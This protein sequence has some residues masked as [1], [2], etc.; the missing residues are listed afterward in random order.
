[1]KDPF[2]SPPASFVSFLQPVASSLSLPV[3][4]LHIHEVLLG[5]AAYHVLDVYISP[6]LSRAL[7]PQTYNSLNLRTRI[8]WNMRVAAWAQAVFISALALGVKYADQE[9]ADMSWNGRLW[10]YSGGIGMVQG[11]ALGYFLWDLSV[12]IIHYSLLG[13]ETLAH[14][15]SALVMILLAFV[16]LPTKCFNWA[17]LYREILL[18]KIL[19][20]AP[21]HA[22]LWAEL[23]H[24]RAEHSIS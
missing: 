24:V 16:S 15:T 2:Y 17:A 7:F 14:A 23:H 13:P 6:L 22:A 19:L 5:W 3:L 1:M 11:F 4:P 9:V 8:N 20:K 10:G 12:C 18:M 21:V